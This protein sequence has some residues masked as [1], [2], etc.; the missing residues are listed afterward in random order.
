MN[1]SGKLLFASNNLFS[2]FQGQLNTVKDRVDEISKNQFINNSDDEIVDHIFNK[3]KIDP[4]DIFE[5]RIERSDTSESRKEK[6]NHFGDIISAPTVTLSFSIPFIGNTEL[7]DYQPSSIDINPPRGEI[8]TPSLN[9]N[10]G[11]LLIQLEYFTNDFDSDTVNKEIAKILESIKKNITSQKR[12]I[13]THDKKLKSQIHNLVASRRMRLNAIMEEEKT[14]QIPLEKK[15]N[16][17]NQTTLPI[18]RRKIPIL[19]EKSESDKSFSISD[20][21]YEEIINLIR[22]QGATYERTPKTYSVHDE[23]EL[24][25]ILLA[26]LNGQYQGHATGETFRNRGKT[27]ICIE[28]ENRAAFV[29]E[30][31]VWVGDKKVLDALDQLL[32]YLTWRD[33]KTALII[34][35]KTVAGFSGIQDRMPQILESHTNF[36][37][38]E[39]TNGGVE[40]RLRLR[41]QDDPERSIA[42]HVL[43]F[44]IYQKNTEVD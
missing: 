16:A 23:E 2:V 36:I 43:L 44:N 24:R 13:E 20:A 10:Q 3:M 27:D 28:V 12:D 31:K 33:V 11:I 5:N 14:I 32:S 17:P 19:K 21:D 39:P 34:F 29:A 9:G 1:T 8:K 35:N 40:W 25:D 41:S 7:W 4:L 30:C 37:S 42:V 26:Q 38:I 22:H 6:K 18:H 15:I